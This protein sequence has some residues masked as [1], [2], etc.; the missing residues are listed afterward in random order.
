MALTLINLSG[1]SAGVA[2]DET[3]INVKEFKTTVEPEFKN[4]VPGKTGE[5]RGA[6][7]A[8]MKKS[9]T[10]SGEVTGNTGI[11]AAVAATAYAASNSSAYFGA[12]T[13]GLYLVRGEVTESRDNGAL[14]EMSAD[15]EAYAGIS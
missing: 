12:P 9:V 5:I 7:L 13:T 4:Y 1:F 8:P 3:G 14:K 6:V 10:I 2:S 11:M 15:F